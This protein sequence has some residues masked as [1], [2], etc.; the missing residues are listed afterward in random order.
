MLASVQ[1]LTLFT[2][3]THWGSSM[4]LVLSLREDQ[5]FTVGDRKIR[6]SA[7]G[8]EQYHPTGAGVRYWCRGILQVEDTGALHSVGTDWVP[9]GEGVLVR[10]GFRKRRK[11]K[12]LSLQ[13]MSAGS[14]IH[15]G[16]QH[17]VEQ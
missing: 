12:L 15:R 17:E 9:L 11:G 16:E 5:S 13:I 14:E 1:G 7:V 8:D 6:C 10:S 4:P 3:L 2:G